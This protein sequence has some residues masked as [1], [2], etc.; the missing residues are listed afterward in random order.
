MGCSASPCRLGEAAH[1][2]Q[3]LWL[4]P[5]TP[6]NGQGLAEGPRTGRSREGALRVVVTKRRRLG[7]NGPGGEERPGGAGVIGR[8]GGVKWVKHPDVLL[9]KKLG[10]KAPQPGPL[11]RFPLC[12]SCPSTPCLGAH[13]LRYR[14]PG[15]ATRSP[16][17]TL[18]LS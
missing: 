18:M 7:Q 16:A 14:S 8:A 6:G 15:R 13:P 12:S 1:L 17:L 9:N 4:K 11:V 10:N 2:P 5:L 3:H